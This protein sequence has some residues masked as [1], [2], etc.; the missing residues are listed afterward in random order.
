[1]NTTPAWQAAVNGLPTNPSAV[2]GS[3]QVNQMLGTHGITEVYEG[4]KLVR[5]LGGSNLQWNTF[6]NTTDIDQPFILPGGSTSIGRVTLPI[7]P[8]GAGADLLV[9]LFP[10]NGSGAPNL[11]S[12]L[13][14]TTVPA[15]WIN[16]M[17][18]PLGLPSGG[19]LASPKFNTLSG[20]GGIGAQ[21][22]AGPVGDSSG[23]AQNSSVTVSG[24]Y[25]ITAGGS[26][27][28]PV[29]TVN[30]IPYLGGTTLGRGVPQTPLPKPT[31][32]GTLAATP[33]SLIYAGGINTTTAI[34]TVWVAS[35]NPNTGQVGSWSSQTALP[36]ALFAAS[37]AVWNNTVYVIGGN[38]GSVTFSSVYF[39]S[40]SNGQITS[41]NSG[42]ALPQALNS[43]ICGVVGNWLIVAGGSTSGS[44]GSPTQS[45]SCYFSAIQP[46]GSLGAW[47]TGPSLTLGVSAYSPGWDVVVTDSAIIAFCGYAGGSLTTYGIAILPVSPLG[48]GE[49][50]YAFQWRE[51]G[52][53]MVA[54]FPL[55]NGQ[56]FV[57]NPNIPV[58]QYYYTTLSPVPQISVPLPASGLTAGSTYHVV[59]QQRQS[60][61][62]SD[63]LSYG[64]TQEG[65]IATSGSPAALQSPRHANT[66]T[67]V[68]AS[69]TWTLPMT[70]YDN[71]PAGQVLHTWEDPSVGNSGSNINSSLA[72][73][74]TTLVRNQMGL[75]T[76]VC[77][78][79]TL[80]ANPLNS[81]P[82]FTTG[83]TGWT[84]TNCTLTQ[85]N[86]QTHG[87][88]PFS[89]LLAPN[90]TSAT[91]LAESNK[92][93]VQANISA[94]NAPNWCQAQGWVYS[95]TGYGSVSLSV[96]WYDSAGTL[97]STS[98]NV[99]SVP[100]ATWT[101]LNNYFVGPVG[102]S[103][104]TLV[105]TESG[106]PAVG[107]TLYLSN[108]TLALAPEC[109]GAQSSVTQ[110][111]YLAGAQW[112]PIG[113]TQV[114]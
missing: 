59:V 8:T 90:G 24:N 28:A 114:A 44:V 13:A 30:T 102:A 103:Q 14:A 37:G 68:V 99:V 56:W 106:T 33:T 104:A 6:G 36:A 67:Q 110:V 95:P 70:V 42:P 100:A 94:V 16:N 89:G 39:A 107:N 12:P 35:W 82:T 77:E 17:A 51:G 63:Y 21:P 45:A 65:P 87:G 49:R 26:T 113:V 79:T 92:G 27:T 84:A 5:P 40:V 48:V 41:W 78:A 62:A 91:V 60:Q 96:K 53:E 81:N 105:P 32:Y 38:D 18:A 93:P 71:T 47:Q 52:V 85:S 15:A 97:L 83:V 25:M 54:G 66:W 98:S 88:L 3:A 112:P 109:V 74:T 22:W 76:G 43:A 69:G 23:V 7:M 20:T 64:I 31:Y 61:S 29:T 80:P 9:T 55:G 73:R 108:V 34:S 57:V 58:S 75:L 4:V 86:V 50:W 11:T 1:M 10:D 72:A 19:P 111:N 2:N 46:D 101:Y